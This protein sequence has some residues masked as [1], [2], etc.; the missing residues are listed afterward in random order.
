MRASELMTSPAVT[1]RPEA[2]LKEA[3][4][5]LVERD[6][7]AA[8]VVDAGGRLV[9]VVSEAD[10]LGGDIFEP[11]PT[12]H[13]IPLP[14]EH[15]LPPRSVAEVMTTEP[16]VLPA[17]VDAAQVAAVL[18]GQQLKSVP[19][20][21]CGRVVGMVSRRDLLRVLI[22][23]DDMVNQEVLRRLTGYPRLH[24]WQVSTRDGIVEISD[25]GDGDLRRI[26]INLARTV[27]GVVRARLHTSTGPGEATH[28]EEVR[29]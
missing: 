6:V 19:V 4:A 2:T 20:M 13:M 15:E 7:T 24:E 1:V 8:P 12:A 14:L 25:P 21:D 27:P 16:T 17:D 26:A 28:R 29:Q 22:R 18:V 10:V 3:A 23:D 11:D 9:G 5:V